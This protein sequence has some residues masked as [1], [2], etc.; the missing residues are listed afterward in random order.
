VE[1]PK[2]FC[3]GRIARRYVDTILRGHARGAFLDLMAQFF[4][5]NDAAFAHKEWDRIQ[6]RISSAL[7]RLAEENQLK[8]APQLTLKRMKELR[9]TLNNWIQM[10]ECPGEQDVTRIQQ[11]KA[12]KS[13]AKRKRIAKAH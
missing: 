12:D 3:E 13:K 6:F 10:R 7:E 9:E 5:L 2:E 8:P 4:L 1:W 11:P